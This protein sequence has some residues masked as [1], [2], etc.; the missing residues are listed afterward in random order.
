MNRFFTFIFLTISIVS[1][2]QTKNNKGLIDSMKFVTLMPHC[3]DDEQPDS[4]SIYWKVVKLKLEVVD[5]LIEI[6]DDTTE[7]KAIVRWF[8]GHWTVGD[9]SYN[10]IEEIIHGIPTFDLLGIK[11]DENI[12]YSSYWFFVRSDIRNR[13]L[14]KEKLKKWYKKNKANLV[15]ITSEWNVSECFYHNPNNGYYE[16]KSEEK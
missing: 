5:E 11:Y 12:G 9:I 8:G 1:F 4:N 6:I 2:G 7:T 16:S 3:L 13:Q 14:F 15:W 10:A